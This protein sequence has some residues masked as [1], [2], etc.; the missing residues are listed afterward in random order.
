MVVAVGR[1][2]LTD[3]FPHDPARSPYQE[4]QRTVCAGLYTGLALP[5]PIG[6]SYNISPGVGEIFQMPM[7]T[8]YGVASALLVEAVPGGPLD[9][10]AHLSYHDNRTGFIGTCQRL[11]AVHAPRIAER[12]DGALD[13]LG[14]DDLI[15]GAL[16][17]VVRRPWT[18]LPNGRL[19][20]AIGDAWITNDPITGQGANLGSHCAWVAAHAIAA[21][22]PFDEAFTADST[23]RCGGSLAPSQHGQTPSFNHPPTT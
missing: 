15:Q 19:A 9:V 4:P 6:L 2:S 10:L 12:I 14:P 1:R 16:T 11:L 8:R 22:G 20:V 17:P 23:T 5:D 21:D 3:L 13:L 18:R 7:W